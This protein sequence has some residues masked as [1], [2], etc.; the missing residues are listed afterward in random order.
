MKQLFPPEFMEQLKQKNDIVEV[1]GSYI[2]LERRGYTYW[3]CCPFHHEK[4]P[5]FAVNSG[6]R[7]RSWRRVPG[8]K[9]PPTTTG[10]P[11]SLPAAKRSSTGCIF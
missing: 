6:R 3:A 11:R 9:F 2:K 5:S 10:R 1:I 4:T 8:W 7:W